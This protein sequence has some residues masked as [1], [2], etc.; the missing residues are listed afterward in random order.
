MAKLSRIGDTN[1]AG[2]RILTGSNSVFAN[3]KGV[4]LHTS[5]IS[6]HG[7]DKHASARTT[8]GSNTVYA[9]NKP[10]LKVGSGNTCGHVITQGSPDVNVD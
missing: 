4:G 6:S 2:G 1:N 5:S 9:D 8:F 7:K 3:G 10:V